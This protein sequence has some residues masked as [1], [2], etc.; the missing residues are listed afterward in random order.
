[1]FG[2]VLCLNDLVRLEMYF[3]ALN[4]PPKSIL[5]QIGS[6]SNFDVNNECLDS[7]NV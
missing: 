7:H 6:N 2:M 1:M 3:E 4:E 5:V